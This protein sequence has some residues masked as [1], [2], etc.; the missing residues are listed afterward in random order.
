MT[1]L[2]R[3]FHVVLADL[4]GNAVM[5]EML[6]KIVALSLSGHGFV[7]KKKQERLRR[8]SSPPDL[9]VLKS[10]DLAKAQHL[11]GHPLADIEGRA[12]LTEGQGDRHAFM[13]E[14]ENFS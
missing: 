6:S 2:S 7:R 11:M 4:G 10:K 13:A 14:L 5:S 9:T 3:K 1:V 8:G 12:R